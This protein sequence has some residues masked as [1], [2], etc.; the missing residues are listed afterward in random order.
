M[1]WLFVIVLAYLFFSLSSFGDKLVLKGPSKAVSYAFY[2][3]VL[4][5]LLVFLLPFIGFEIPPTAMFFWLAADAIAFILGLYFGFLAVDEFEVSRASATI[6][7]MQPIFIFFISLALFGY[8]GMGAYDILAFLLLFGGS[9]LISFEKKPR[10]TAKF[11]KLTLISSIMYGADYVLIKYIFADTGFAAGFI[12]RGI[13]VGVMA[14]ALLLSKNNRKE[15][16]AKRNTTNK[17]LQKTFFAT[18]VCGGIATALQSYGI[19]LAPVALLPI[20]NSLRGIQ[21]VFL[22]GLTCFTSM[23]FPKI[24]KEKI[25]GQIMF[26]KGVAVLLIVAGLGILVF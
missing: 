2:A 3:G 6:G 17:K 12:W 20:A 16:F 5:I 4:N 24:L 26:Q 9:L 11:L 23:F 18:Q 14:A 21:Y 22:L 19:Y 7:A 10:L 8:Q 1:A 25:S 15:I 13:F